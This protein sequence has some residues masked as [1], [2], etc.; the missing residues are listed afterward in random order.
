MATADPALLDARIRA[1]EAAL[2][3][4][5][6]RTLIEHTLAMARGV[7]VRVVEYPAVEQPAVDPVDAATHLPPILLLHG[8]G[9]VSAL[10]V[11]LLG[12]LADRRV[13][14]VD[15]PGHG[16]SGVDILP[17]GGGLRTHVVEVLDQVLGHFGADP[18]DV[19]GHSLGGQFALYL[20][21]AHPQR[22]RRIVLLG[23]PGAAFSQAR[24]TLGMRL[25]AL[26][27]AGTALLSLS[28]SARTHDR[29]VGRLVGARALD[30][31][32]GEIGEIGYLSS[33]RS[34]FAPSVASLFRAMATPFAVRAD[35]ALTANELAHLTVP[36]LIVWG[37]RDVIL[38]PEHGRASA[39]AMPNAT[40][41]EVDGGHAPWLDD[42]ERVGAAVSAFLSD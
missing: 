12:A 3:R 25:A 4:R 24:P 28:T 23:A 1:A 37:V 14:A 2:A 19:I 11:P 42:P 32:P 17:G 39:D 20:A 34:D 22:L 18:V 16:L 41:L 30:G 27:G 31:Y 35:V 13:L 7:K 21:L 10:A 40:I 36:T 29:A 9:S 33:Q 38:S 8:I 6:G 26:P 15:W 5:Y